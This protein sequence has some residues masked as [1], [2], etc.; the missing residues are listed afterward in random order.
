MSGLKNF[1][2]FGKKKDSGADISPAEIIAEG[3]NGGDVGAL[4]TSNGNG[5]GGINYFPA[6]GGGSTPVANT[7]V[8]APSVSNSSVTNTQTIL[9]NVVEPDPYFLRQSG[10]AI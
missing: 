2:S 10:W 9:K 8:N 5:G 7:M 4:P 3:G 6:E 1:F